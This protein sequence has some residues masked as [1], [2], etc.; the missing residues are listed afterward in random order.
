[1]ENLKKGKF[2]VVLCFYP[3]LAFVFVILKLPVLC[4]L[5]LLAAILIE[6][7]EWA[8]RQTVQAVMLS[9][10]VTFFSNIV[11]WAVSL[12]SIPFFS[13]VLSVV[14]T[15]FS[16]LVY[17]AAIVFSIL[18]IVRVMKDQEADLPLLSEIAYRIYGRRKPKPAPAQ[19]P[20]YGGSQP[21]QVPT[22]YQQPPQQPYSDP[23]SSGQQGG[24]AQQNGPRG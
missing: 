2:G 13:G 7:E 9:I 15:V 21:G 8:G 4:A 22:Q 23:R 20:P 12:F 16:I 18:G 24:G 6:K 17:L 19:Y 10:L 5:L 1:M 14:S 3:I 11:P